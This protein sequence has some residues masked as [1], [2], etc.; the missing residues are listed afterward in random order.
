MEGR[1]NFPLGG[2]IFRRRAGVLCLYKAPLLGV[3]LGPH[4]STNA[5][6]I[7]K[8][9]SYPLY[10]PHVLESVSHSEKEWARRTDLEWFVAG[11][12]NRLG[13]AHRKMHHTPK[14]GLL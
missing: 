5:V 11:R 7:D 14:S 6:S 13:I 3:K 10:I 12:G 4:T 8:G 2:R 1:A 9:L